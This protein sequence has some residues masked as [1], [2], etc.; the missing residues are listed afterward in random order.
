VEAEPGEQAS[1]ADIAAQLRRL[2]RRLSLVTSNSTDIVVGVRADG[3]VE[4]ASRPLVLWDTVEPDAL[5]GVAPWDVIHPDDLASSLAALAEIADAGRL[6]SPQVIRLRKG[7]EHRWV[8]VDG[9]RI[10]EPE[11]EAII[12]LSFRVCDDEIRAATALAE[13]EHRYRL[14]AENATDVVYSVDTAGLCNWVSPSVT[15]VLG[16]LPEDFTNRSIVEFIHPV[17]LAENLPKFQQVLGSG[18]ARGHAEM[19][20]RTADGSW[21][22][23]SVTGR[24]MRDENGVLLGGIESLRDIQAEVEA[25]AALEESERQFRLAMHGSPAGMAVVGLDRSFVSVNPAL[26][27]MLGHTEGWLCAHGVDDV[28]LPSELFDDHA[29]RAR[30]LVGEQEA[31]VVERSLL[32]SDGSTIAALHSTGLLRDHQQ[33]PMFFVSQFVDITARK[34]AEAD[35]EFAATHDSLTGLANR[36]NLV[37]EIQRAIS[38]SNRSGRPTAVVM[39][40]LD[41]FKYVNDSLG[42]PVGDELL[43]RSADRLRATVREGDLVARHGGDE[44]V[45]VMRDLDD[46]AESVRIAQRIVDAFRSPFQIGPAELYTTA[47]IGIAVARDG[48]DADTLLSE[49]DTALYVAKADG[50]DRYSLFN[51]ELRAAVTER[52]RIE[53]GLRH[54]LERDEFEVWYQPEVDLADGHVTAVEA[55]LR[56]RHPSGELYTADRFIGVA[57]DSGLIVELGSMVIRQACCQTTVWNRD[58]ADRPVVVRVNLSTRQLAEVDLLRTIDDAVVSTGASPSWLCFEITETAILRDL[59]VVDDNL[60]GI[61]HRGIELALDDFGTGYA[62]L[63]YLREIPVA[64]LKLDRSFVRN[65]A[66]SEFDRRLVAGVVGLAH[67]LHVEVTAEGVEEER[68]AEILRE[69]GCRRAQG[70]LYSGAV[71][72]A[73]ID[74]MLASH[75]RPG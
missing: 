64:V 41:H 34:T 43:R 3:T 4:W 35:L 14:L 6:A 31:R 68:Q 23:M 1:A 9:H 67:G 27:E 73:A 25:R 72:A 10:D 40:D 45:V 16:W 59:A 18:G 63:A 62:S 7:D 20:Y 19:R 61:R 57:E 53:G 28:L 22:W 54:A 2:Q 39:L 5:V 46:P 33:R 49:A 74:E 69:L 55:L 17:D 12:V 65:I 70:F 38:S 37:D 29:T 51:D 58:R 52:L 71:P 13:S 36:A 8:T 32:T 26:C 48:V 24:V 42:H 21:R 75:N 56:W 11:D 66:D 50:R 15:E 47:S 44:F 30:L 60:R